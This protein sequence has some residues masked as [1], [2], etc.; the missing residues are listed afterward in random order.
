MSQ[1]LYHDNFNGRVDGANIAAS[2]QQYASLFG[3]PDPDLYKDDYHAT[4]G[5]YVVLGDDYAGAALNQ[6]IQTHHDM[7]MRNYSVSCR[8]YVQEGTQLGAIYLCGRIGSSDEHYGACFSFSSNA[9]NDHPHDAT[10]DWTAN[11]AYIYKST[12]SA[13]TT[14]TSASQTLNTGTW[15][16]I[17]LTMHYDSISLFLDDT[18]ILSTTDSTYDGPGAVGFGI[19]TLAAG[20]DGN[21]EVHF[22]DFSVDGN[23][24]HVFPQYQ[25]A[26]D[27]RRDLII[28]GMPEDGGLTMQRAFVYH[29]RTGDWTI[30]DH[31]IGSL[32]NVLSDLSDRR[33][34][35]GETSDKKLYEHDLT[36]KTRSGSAVSST[37]ASNWLEIEQGKNTV[38]IQWVKALI[39][40]SASNVIKLSVEVTDD[41]SHPT[42]HSQMVLPSGLEANEEFPLD[43][44][45]GRWVR[46]KVQH[47][48]ST[49]DLFLRRLGLGIGS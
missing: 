43:G 11:T 30:W 33:V 1:K 41:P 44:M 40:L 36:T 34:I 7:S 15:Y 17:R 26:Y 28:W 29:R 20:T 23:Y 45:A 18:Q 48:D 49:G 38:P 4:G 37:W 8:V 47:T 6:G 42:V 35:Y 9:N 21:C 14:L 46:F 13:V 39:R 10:A 22:D 25:A 5:A 31:E 16:L 24:L 27:E 19:T 12:G 32:G 3:T 2:P